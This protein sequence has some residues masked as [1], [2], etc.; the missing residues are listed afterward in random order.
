MTTPS[1][2]TK[3][4]SRPPPPRPK[5][6]PSQMHKQIAERPFNKNGPASLRVTAFL[7]ADHMSALSNHPPQPVPGCEKSPLPAEMPIIRACSHLHL[8]IGRRRRMLLF[9][10]RRAITGG[11]GRAT[12][13]GQPRARSAPVIRQYF[14]GAAATISGAS[15]CRSPAEPRRAG[16]R[17]AE[18]RRQTRME[19]D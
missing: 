17:N 12:P 11:G 10:C 19:M 18:K 15:L 9:Y 3:D 13:L 16:Q 5:T 14:I 8:M 1:S 6:T 4:D 7:L 2:T